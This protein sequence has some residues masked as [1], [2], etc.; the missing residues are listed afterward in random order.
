MSSRLSRALSLFL[1]VLMLMFGFLK[2]FQ[3]IRGWFD[4]QIQQSHLPH[5][6]ILAGKVTEMM[7]GIFFLLPW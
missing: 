3:P 6:A 2:F 4:V 7:T 1:G 5:E